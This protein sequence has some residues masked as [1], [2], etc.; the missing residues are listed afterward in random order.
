MNFGRQ[1]AWWWV[2]QLQRGQR[3]GSRATRRSAQTAPGCRDV[4]AAKPEGSCMAPART[5]SFHGSWLLCFSSAA[6]TGEHRNTHEVPLPTALF[7]V[8]AAHLMKALPFVGPPLLDISTAPR[9]IWK[10]CSIHIMLSGRNWH[11]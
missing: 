2:W 5:H 7:P 3:L 11:R 9:L 1:L 4:P 6:Q 8:G 10:G